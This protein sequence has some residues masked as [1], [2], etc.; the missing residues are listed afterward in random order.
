[1]ISFF[2]SPYGVLSL[3]GLSVMISLASEPI[4]VLIVDGHNNHDW[5][6]T[7]DSLHATLQATNRFAVEVETAPQ[8]QSIK[9]IRGPKAYAA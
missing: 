2:K 5:E 1:M 4:P 9:G 6:S 8:T 7:T 3:L